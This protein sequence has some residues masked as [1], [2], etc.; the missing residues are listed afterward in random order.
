MVEP[1]LKGKDTTVL[2][3]T[4]NCIKGER[5]AEG[6][7]IIWELRRFMFAQQ[8]KLLQLICCESPKAQRHREPESCRIFNNIRH[9]EMRHGEIRTLLKNYFSCLDRSCGKGTPSLSWGWLQLEWC[10][11]GQVKTAISCSTRS[12]GEGGGDI[13]PHG[14]TYDAYVASVAYDARMALLQYEGNG[15][16]GRRRS[17]QPE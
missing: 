1:R 3:L 16:Q 7:N 11:V 8:I 13:P 9:G 4:V 6:G 2:M 12:D 14:A 17:R 5:I 10:I 15:G